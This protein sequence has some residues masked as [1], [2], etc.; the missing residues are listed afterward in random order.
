MWKLSEPGGD[1]EQCFLRLRQTEYYASEQPRPNTLERM[2][3]VRLISFQGAADRTK[4]NS[5]KKFPKTNSSLARSAD[6]RL[7]Q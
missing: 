1:A 5:S 6:T 2:P 4:S 3:G 7:I